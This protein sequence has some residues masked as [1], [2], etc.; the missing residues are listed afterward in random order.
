MNSL[1]WGGSC[2]PDD[3][4]PAHGFEPRF[5]DSKSLV[6]P[7]DDAGRRPLS[8]CRLGAA[9]QPRSDTR[10]RLASFCALV[11]QIHHEFDALRVGVREDA[12]TQVED[13]TGG[14]ASALEDVVD[15]PGE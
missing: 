11:D 1:H 8:F 15:A 4:V 3:E 7:L 6:L 5:R 10:R 14:A 12:M 9:S 2:A 13:V